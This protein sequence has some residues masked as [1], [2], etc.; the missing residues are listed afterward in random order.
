MK[1]LQAV[2]TRI[3]NILK[4]RGITQNSLNESA[5]I[6]YNK[7]KSSINNKEDD[8]NLEIIMKVIRGLNITADEFFNDSI[9]EK[10]NLEIN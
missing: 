5:K 9:F 1:I 3:E 8:I 6:S 10:N 2:L 7:I 4:E